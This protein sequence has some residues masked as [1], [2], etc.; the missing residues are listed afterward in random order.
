MIFFCL[1][2]FQDSYQR[3]PLHLCA[4][5]GNTE[6]LHVLLSNGA[7]IASMDGEQHSAVHWA[8]G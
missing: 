2:S 6:T 8:T 1:S 7:D 3:S 4:I 5:G